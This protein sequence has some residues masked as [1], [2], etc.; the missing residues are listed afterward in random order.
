TARDVMK[1]LAGAG[2]ASLA[3]DLPGHAATAM[4]AGH[5]KPNRRI[6][7]DAKVSDHFAIIPT[8]QIPR[9]LKPEEAKIF[10]MVTRRFVA[11]FFPAAEFEVTTRIT[12][13]DAD[14]FKTEGRVIVVPGWMQV[15]GK[16]A[17]G[18]GEKTM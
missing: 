3:D 12:R 1:T 10:D 16:Q 18:D 9:S 14:A 6:F 4:S 15:Y 8:G 13:I 2:G 7:D 11:A 5:V 17:A